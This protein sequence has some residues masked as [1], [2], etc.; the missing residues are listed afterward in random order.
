MTYRNQWFEELF[1]GRSILQVAVDVHRTVIAK[2]KRPAAEHA[3]DVKLLQAARDN[4][5]WNGQGQFYIATYN[6]I[7]NALDETINHS[8]HSAA[9]IT[10]PERE[11]WQ[12]VNKAYYAPEQPPKPQ[13]IQV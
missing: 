12:Q 2:H 10:C 6:L 11:Y 1:D 9:D 5:K 3:D 7:L 8:F 13:K 4:W